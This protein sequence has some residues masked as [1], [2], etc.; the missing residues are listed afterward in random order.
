MDENQGFLPD[1]D[2][3]SWKNKYIAIAQEAV[4][5]WVEEVKAKYGKVGTKYACVG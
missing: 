1:F 4:P 5:K 3:D 2:F